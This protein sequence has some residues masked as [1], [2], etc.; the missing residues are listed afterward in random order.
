MYICQRIS[1]KGDCMSRLLLTLLIDFITITL[2][3]FIGLAFFVLCVIFSFHYGYKYFSSFQHFFLT[4]LLFFLFGTY[5][6]FS[7]PC[8]MII[9]TG[10]KGLAKLWEELWNNQYI[11]VHIN[12]NFLFGIVFVVFLNQ[13]DG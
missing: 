10:N 4:N 7:I 9:Y 1:E 11:F 5:F 2:F 12:L 8:F 3:I 13:T 6:S